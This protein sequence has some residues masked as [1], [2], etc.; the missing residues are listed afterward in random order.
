MAAVGGIVLGLLWGEKL[1]PWIIADAYGILYSMPP[2]LMPYNG[3]YSLMAALGALIRL[4]Q[5]LLAG[6][7]DEIVPDI[8]ASSAPVETPMEP[9][10]V[11]LSVKM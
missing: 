5:R 8:P 2:L 3:Y 9:M 1:F 11:V 6:G 10:E 4:I 7:S